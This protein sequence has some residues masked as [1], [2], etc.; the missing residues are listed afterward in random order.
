MLGEL[1]PGR[2]QRARRLVHVFVSKG[3]QGATFLQSNVADCSITSH[4]A[5]RVGRPGKAI[6]CI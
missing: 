2:E 6:M 5:L 3:G 4:A 1:D